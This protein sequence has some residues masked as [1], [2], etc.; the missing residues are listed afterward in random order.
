MCSSDLLEDTDPIERNL[1]SGQSAT[2]AYSPTASDEYQRFPVTVTTS[3]NFVDNNREAWTVSAAAL[4]CDCLLCF[5]LRHGGYAYCRCTSVRYWI[6]LNLRL[7]STIHS[8]TS[9]APSVFGLAS[10]DPISWCSN[11]LSWSLSKWERTSG[12]LHL[13]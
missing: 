9:T 10:V 3:A 1:Y 2:I 7:C 5:L 13:C 6:H 12:P 4:L 11:I 8:V